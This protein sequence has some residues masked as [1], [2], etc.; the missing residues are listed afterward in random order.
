MN[1]AAQNQW[2]ALPDGKRKKLKKPTRR[3]RLDALVNWYE[4][5]KP[6]MERVLPGGV[7]VP[8][9]TLDRWAAKVADNRW[10]YRGWTITR[11]VEPVVKKLR[12]KK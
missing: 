7:A 6:E 4:Q 5:N 2:V 1:Q 11:A 9:T 12:I 3:D 8:A 10:I